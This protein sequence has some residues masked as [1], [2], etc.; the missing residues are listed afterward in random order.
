[1]SRVFKD[2][3][4]LVLELN[5]VVAVFDFIFVNGTVRILPIPELM[6]QSSNKTLKLSLVIKKKLFK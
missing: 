4:L 5:I 3:Y 1:M 2:R 6:E